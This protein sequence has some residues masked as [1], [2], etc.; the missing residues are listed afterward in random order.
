[1]DRKL[2]EREVERYRR[3]L[4]LG[5]FTHEHQERLKDSTVLIAGIGGLGGTAAVYLAVAGIGKMKLAHYGNL[6]LSNM[7]R[8]ILMKDDWIG[9][10]RVI[11]AKRSIR[12]I[13]PDVAIEIYNERTTGENVEELLS[14]VHLALSARP[15]F[16]ERRVLNAACVRRNIP[17]VEAAMNGMEG[18]LFNVI[19]GETPCLN[20]LY[21][22][23]DPHWEELGFP[24]LG[25]VSGMLGCIMALE[26]IKLLTG[27]GKPLASQVLLFN[28]VD[29]EFRKLRIKRDGGCKICGDVIYKGIA[30]GK[31]H[32]EC[33]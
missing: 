26:A 32:Y 22:E 27:F 25:A 13:N 9:K 11:Q 33:V 2:S 7:N 17:M 16:S 18:Y 28:T 30:E 23:D 12:E 4:I 24:V 6:T 8:Q 1:M 29:M 3:Q 21:A 10:S 19:P 5:G 20:C 15:N 14:G 31:Q